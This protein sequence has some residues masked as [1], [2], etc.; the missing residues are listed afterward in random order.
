MRKAHEGWKEVVKIGGTNISD[1]TTLFDQ[2]DDRWPFAS[3]QR[4]DALHEYKTV[5]ELLYD[6]TYS[7]S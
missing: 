3:I 2:T 6:S 4:S 1:D 5:D 7:Q